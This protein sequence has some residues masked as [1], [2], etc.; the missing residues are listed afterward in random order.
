MWCVLAVCSFVC[1]AMG[2]LDILVA[3]EATFPDRGWV[4]GWHHL[5]AR[6]HCDEGT[7]GDPVAMA[8]TTFLGRGWVQGWHCLRGRCQRTKGMPGIPA[9]TFL[10]RGRIWV[11]IAWEVSTTAGQQKVPVHCK[12]THHPVFVINSCIG[13]QL[14]PWAEPVL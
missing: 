5:R 4:R 12:G 1:S 13:D 8:A 11:V 14:E 3:N 6:H 7:L 9:E 2:T 10:G